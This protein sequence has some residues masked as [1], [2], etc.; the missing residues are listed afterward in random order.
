VPIYE[1]ECNG[2]KKHRFEVMQRISDPPLQACEKCGKE[3]Q[4]LISM[5]QPPVFLCGGFMGGYKGT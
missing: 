4:R 3:V 1:Y 2:E 5:T